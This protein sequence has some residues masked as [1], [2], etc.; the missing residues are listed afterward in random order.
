M[1]LVAP[2]KNMYRR[3]FPSQ[4]N[5]SILAYVEAEL[6]RS[7][8]VKVSDK[9]YFTSLATQIKRNHKV[10]LFLRSSVLP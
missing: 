5:V 7:D 9:D 3:Y 6:D 10:D 8:G 4:L 1:L 2:T